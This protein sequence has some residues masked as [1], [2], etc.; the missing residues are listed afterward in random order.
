MI[1]KEIY[2]QDLPDSVI[3]IDCDINFSDGKRKL[4]YNL[5]E[6]KLSFRD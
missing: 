1:Q 2:E 4:V 3:K 6:N 5:C